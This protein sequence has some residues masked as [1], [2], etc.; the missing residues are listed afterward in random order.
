[1]GERNLANLVRLGVDHVDYRI[2]PAVERKFTYE[3]LRRYGST[4]IPMHMAIFN[5]PA[6]IAAR[7]KIPL[8]VWGENSA[9]EYGGSQDERTGFRL[10][11]AWVKR[12]GVTHGT[13]AHDWLT[14]GLSKAELAAYFGPTAAELESAGV[15]AVFLGYY[16]EWDPETTRAVAAAHGFA[17]DPRGAR[18]GLYD[19]ADIDDDFISVHHWLKWYKFGFTRLFDNLSIEIRNGRVSRAEAVDIVRR[20]GDDT[21]YADIRKL[22]EFLEITVDHFFDICER[23]RNTAIWHRDDTTWKIRN[24]LIDDW[25][26]IDPRERCSAL[27]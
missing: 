7:Y 13:T 11:E 10:D 22:C 18:T 24:F 27:S 3:A 9:F 26:W 16:F 2:R 21:P 4:A 6:A 23:F 25:T 17:A 12:H 8:I 20:T 14:K 1:V 5:I 19:Y 15:L